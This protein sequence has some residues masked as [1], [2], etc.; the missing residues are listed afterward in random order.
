MFIVNLSL[1]EQKIKHIRCQ[2][3]LCST[4]SQCNIR[5]NVE[6]LIVKIS[7][8][9]KDGLVVNGYSNVLIELSFV[10]K[11]INQKKDIA[12]T[13]FFTML[14]ES[15]IGKEYYD[16]KYSDKTQMSNELQV[17]LLE[18]MNKMSKP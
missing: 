1:I 2:N 18:L 14:K 7:C 6:N 17:Q 12:S 4:N 9:D 16:I 13:L 11:F 10:I 15:C 8:F 3:L 5:P